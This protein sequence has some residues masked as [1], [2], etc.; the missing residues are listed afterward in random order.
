MDEAENLSSTKDAHSSA[1][2][3]REAFSLLHPTKIGRYTILGLL[4]KGGFWLRPPTWHE[5]L[6]VTL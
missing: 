4:G 2:D 5:T 1:E 6:P 3:S